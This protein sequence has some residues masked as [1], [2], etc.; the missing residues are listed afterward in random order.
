VTSGTQSATVRLVP[1][2]YTDPVEIITAPVPATS[3]F[4]PVDAK[5]VVGAVAPASQTRS[6]SC[7]SPASNTECANGATPTPMRFTG[8]SNAE[9]PPI[10]ATP[11]NNRPPVGDDSNHGLAIVP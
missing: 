8:G 3:P 4:I 1:R 7:S 10:A 2:P 5:I 9:D 6:R 11:T